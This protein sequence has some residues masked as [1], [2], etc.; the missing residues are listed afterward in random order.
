MNRK[1]EE[2]GTLTR[3]SN[4]TS[5]MRDGLKLIEIVER[6]TGQKVAGYHLTPMSL[7]E[8]S[9]NVSAALRQIA[10]FN[11]TPVTFCSG[12]DVVS[13]AL[14]QTKKLIAFLRATFDLSYIYEQ[15]LERERERGKS[16]DTDVGE[17]VEE[18]SSTEESGEELSRDEVEECIEESEST[19]LA[20]HVTPLE[21]E[22]GDIAFDSTTIHFDGNQE[23]TNETK[24]PAETYGDSDIPA[25]PL[26]IMQSLE[27][28]Q[29]LRS[30]GKGEHASSRDYVEVSRLKSPRGEPR[31]NVM[32]FFESFKA[33]EGI[34]PEE[35][36]DEQN[37]EH[38][39]NLEHGYGSENEE[40]YEE[41]QE[42]VDYEAEGEKLAM[43]L[44]D[45][46]R[47][48]EQ[49][50]QRAEAEALLMEQKALAIEVL[51]GRED[52]MPLQLLRCVACW[53]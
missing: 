44:E 10:V 16:E 40:I 1:F 37:D 41:E 31:A 20:S 52:D 36:H 30:A 25:L 21:S 19:T 49:E 2:F 24:V 42:E 9:M 27:R 34:K 17:D 43:E 51:L 12:A 50:A 13:G 38:Q 35:L 7:I 15:F 39:H 32:S 48:N 29:H 6:F 33:E 4:L 11:L 45:E 26:A 28:H 23:G 5:D 46:A 22:P 14:G 53:E 18:E 3:V 8:C 47:K